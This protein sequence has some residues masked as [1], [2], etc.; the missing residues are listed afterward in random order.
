MK[1]EKTERRSERD[2]ERHTYTMR[3]RE[4]HGERQICVY[5]KGTR[6]HES[7]RIEETE[8]HR[9]HRERD[10]KAGRERCRDNKERNTEGEKTE[11]HR[12]ETEVTKRGVF[13][14]FPSFG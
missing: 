2:R 11:R 8:R 3:H 6:S 14:F 12:T 7:D 9:G 5:R 10:Q 1:P 4:K 13:G